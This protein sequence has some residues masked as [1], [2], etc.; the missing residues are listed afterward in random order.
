MRG[1]KW[2]WG[3]EGG[4]A[5]RELPSSRHPTIPWDDFEAVFLLCV[6]VCWLIIMGICCGSPNGLTVV[7]HLGTNS[8][9]SGACVRTLGT[10]QPWRPTPPPP[11]PLHSQ[12]VRWWDDALQVFHGANQSKHSQA[13][14]AAGAQIVV[15]SSTHPHTHYA[16]VL[17]T[18]V[19]QV[20]PSVC[21]LFYCSLRL[22]SLSTLVFQDRACGNSPLCT[23][24]AGSAIHSH[25][26]LDSHTH[27]Y[28]N[29]KP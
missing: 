27:T 11:P 24:Y 7:S 10:N 20:E 12:C 22:Y 18:G 3:G 21:P 28:R 2:A 25:Y 15:P 16:C 13:A 4:G 14:S 1:Q 8:G 5:G 29:D 9:P 17:H 26:S 23:I 6:A 19:F